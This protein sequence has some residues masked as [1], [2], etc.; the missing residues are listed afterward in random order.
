MASPG[1][2][3]QEIHP[4]LENS[5]LDAV[6]CVL[7]LT[8]MQNDRLQPLENPALPKIPFAGKDVPDIG[9]EAYCR[10]LG[11]L[12]DVTPSLYPVVLVYIY[13]VVKQNA[14]LVINS[15][16]IHRLIITSFTIMA[17]F[18]EDLHCD[19][20]YY[21]KAGGIDLGELN[22]LEKEMLATIDF[23][24][25]I[26]PQTYLYYTTSL[27]NHVAGCQ[28]CA[29]RV[30]GHSHSPDPEPNQE[31]DPGSMPQKLKRCVPSPGP[32]LKKLKRCAPFPEPNQDQ[33]TEA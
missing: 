29:T 4:P 14:G 30:S 27:Q 23:D 31:K 12:F 17:K 22:L 2:H 28:S 9:V 5:V 19:N 20:S 15:F 1:T 24:L 6:A 3:L 32:V 26:P 11:E 21:A 8:V 7:Q 13:R 18:H 25:F 33:G 16:T 10:R